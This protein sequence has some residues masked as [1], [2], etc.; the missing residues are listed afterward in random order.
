MF[1][2]PVQKLDFLTLLRSWHILVRSPL[3]VCFAFKQVPREISSPFGL[4]NVQGSGGCVS[5]EFPVYQDKSAFSCG[6]DVNS[7]IFT[8]ILVHWASPYV[9]RR[10]KRIRFCLPSLLCISEAVTSFHLKWTFSKIPWTFQF[11]FSSPSAICHGVCDVFQSWR[12]PPS[13]AVPPHAVVR[14]MWQ[15]KLASCSH[16]SSQL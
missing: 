10:M 3:H 2:L 15:A 5:D 4:Q 6:H 7:K 11:H 14:M 9:R 13:S 12:N 1:S 8:I 16:L